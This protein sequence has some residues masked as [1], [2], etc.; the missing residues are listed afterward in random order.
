MRMMR[1]LNSSIQDLTAV[2]MLGSLVVQIGIIPEPRDKVRYVHTV[3]QESSDSD[4]ESDEEA[5]DEQPAAAILVNEAKPAAATGAEALKQKLHLAKLRLELKKKLRALKKKQTEAT[6]AP[7]SSSS[8]DIA[9]QENQPSNSQSFENEARAAAESEVP[10]VDKAAQIEELRRRQKELKQSN[11][12]SNLKNLV[13]R[14][15]EILRVKGAELSESSEQLQS[16]VGEIKSKQE[17][18]AASEKKIEEMHHRKRIM[19]GMIL[20]VTEKLMAARRNLKEKQT[21]QKTR[22]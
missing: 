13:Q 4:D 7:E 5:E 6:S 10:H 14:Q 22:I 12:L 11:E 21:Q 2:R 8:T 19:E 3:Y 18:L 16:C 20:R 17:Q 15:R 9:P 1:P